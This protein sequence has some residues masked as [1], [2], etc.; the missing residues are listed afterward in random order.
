LRGSLFGLGVVTGDNKSMML[1]APVPNSEPIFTG[2]ELMPYELAT[3]R[4]WLVFD[5]SRLQQVAPD[6]VY[7][8]REKLVYKTISKRLMVAI[9]RTGSLTSNSAN[10]I[11]P[12]NI[13]GNTIETLAALLNSDLYSF[14]NIKLFGGVNKV[15]RANLEALPLPVFESDQITTICNLVAAKEYYAAENFIQRQIFGLS[16]IEILHL[17]KVVGARKRMEKNYGKAA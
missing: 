5:R 10:I 6:E 16:D 12:R 2:K 7:R 14:L 13:P 8:A 3:A 1:H 9:D 4:Q 15:A 17:H 11:V